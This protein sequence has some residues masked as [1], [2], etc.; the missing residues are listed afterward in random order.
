MITLD[1][2]GAAAIQR[3]AAWPQGVLL[4]SHGVLPTMGVMLLVPVLPLLMREFAS[5]GRA[6]YLVPLLLTAPALGIALLSIPAGFL[7][8]RFG[9][10]R[11]L[12]SALA[13]YSLTGIAPFLLSD[14]N[15]IFI[16]RLLLGVWEAAIITL[17]AALIGDLFVGRERDRWLSVTSTMA[18]LSAIVFAA[19]AGFIGS[20]LG[21]RGPILVYGCALF[22]LP[23]MLLLTWN[24]ASERAASSAQ[25]REKDEAFPWLHMLS[26]GAVTICG[27]VIF[28]SL[29]VQQGLA[30]VALGIERPSDI[31]ISAAFV[32]LGVPI[33][34]LLFIP[35]R[36]Y[37]TRLLLT[38]EFFLLSIA[39]GGISQ[40]SDAPTFALAALVGSIGAGLLLPTLITWTI[41]GLPPAFLGRGTGVFQS[42]FALG[43][44]ASA[45]VIPFFAKL[46]A[47]TLLA[48]GLLGL[49]SLVFAIIGLVGWIKRQSITPLMT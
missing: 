44:F 27:S 29:T 39:L 9:H 4:A 41:G 8:D 3:R 18:S 38:G 45:L 26:V 13:F 42:T 12:M 30:L 24:P 17:S 31:G 11:V 5:V 48:F 22:F 1:E 40:A 33:G 15:A 21:W 7:G 47:S 10:R 46:T 25:A 14:F 32:S 19:V 37:S 16:S 36:R 43:Q 35:L 49:F 23:A 34:T 6:D 20:A 2:N 28:Y